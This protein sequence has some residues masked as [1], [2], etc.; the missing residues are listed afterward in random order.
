MKLEEHVA[1]MVSQTIQPIG[2]PHSNFSGSRFV[3][4][5]LE[6]LIRQ[7][8]AE[9]PDSELSKL[10]TRA[11]NER[12][13]YEIVGPWEPVGSAPAGAPGVPQK[14]CGDCGKPLAL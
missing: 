1:H 2:S 6:D 10:I 5:K 3:N 13:L 12:V 8:L 4:E 9:T 7:S 11:L 14:F